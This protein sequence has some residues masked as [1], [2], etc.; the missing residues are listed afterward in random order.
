MRFD[1]KNYAILGFFIIVTKLQNNVQMNDISVALISVLPCTIKTSYALL[2]ST[3]QTQVI[4][5]ITI[6]DTS[7]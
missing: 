7:I 6:F 4:G 3:C 1:Y 5:C 2:L